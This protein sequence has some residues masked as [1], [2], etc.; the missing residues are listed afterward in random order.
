MKKVLFAALPLLVFAL[1][2]PTVSQGQNKA[3]GVLPATK[4]AGPTSKEYD[5]LTNAREVTAKLA[6]VDPG[7]VNF[8][9]KME[10]TAFEP[11][12]NFKGGGGGNNAF[13]QMQRLMRQQPHN[14]FTNNR[15]ANPAQVMRQQMQIQ[16]QMQRQMSQMMAKGGKPNAGNMPYK[17]VTHNKEFQLEAIDKVVVRRLAMPPEFDDNGNKKQLTDAEKRELR[18][19]DPN[20]PGFT[21]KFADLRAGQTVKVYMASVQGKDPKKKADDLDL[22]GGVTR[23]KVRMI[24][25]T[26]DA[27][28]GFDALAADQKKKKKK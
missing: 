14:R 11:N 28:A 15:H 21:A 23:P 13:Q 7:S 12:P 3:K 1:A 20:L 10:Y 24:V 19:K 4:N 25:I 6:F 18:G 2:L 22:D 16:Q 5:Q 8:S 17:Q 9:I 26:Q 27:P